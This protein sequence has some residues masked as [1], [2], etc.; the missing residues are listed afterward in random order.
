MHSTPFVPR[1]AP[2]MAQ[3]PSSG[4]LQAGEAGLS[5]CPALLVADLPGDK[6]LPVCTTGLKACAAHVANAT[7]AVADLPARP[8]LRRV[9]LRG[10]HAL[11]V[12]LCTAPIGALL[13][14]RLPFFT[15][16]Q[17][18]RVRSGHQP[19]PA[20]R[21]AGCGESETGC[22]GDRRTGGRPCSDSGEIAEQHRRTRLCLWLQ[23]TLCLNLGETWRPRARCG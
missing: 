20:R 18:G 8:T 3:H 7:V 15:W 17:R 14:A 19:R 21:R 6:G 16:Q 23:F 13:R 1:A 5:L 9:L 10:Q 2:W 12:F 11:A 22:A 4:A